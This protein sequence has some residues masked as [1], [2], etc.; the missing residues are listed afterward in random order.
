MKIDN[1]NSIIGKKIYEELK[2]SQE[3]K[4]EEN[5][6][7]QKESRDSVNISSEARLIQETL[8][9]VK[10]HEVSREEKVQE[11]KEKIEAGE[12]KVDTQA[13]AQKMLELDEE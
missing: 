2:N 10:N 6:Q 3:P 12:Y 9:E 11:L 5:P 13:L 4:K 8:N 1:H 7:T